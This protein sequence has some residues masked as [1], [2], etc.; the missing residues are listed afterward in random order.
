MNTD[1]E[2][3]L[4]PNLPF[5]RKWVKIYK[6]NYGEL[7]SSTELEKLVKYAYYMKDRVEQLKLYNECFH[8]ILKEQDTKCQTKKT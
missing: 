2:K 5:L 1:L 8:K 7:E 6:Q 4:E 3:Q